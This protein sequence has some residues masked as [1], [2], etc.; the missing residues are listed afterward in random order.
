MHGNMNIQHIC[1]MFLR[2]SFIGDKMG[3]T[4]IQDLKSF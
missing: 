2:I 1:N 3:E 4:P